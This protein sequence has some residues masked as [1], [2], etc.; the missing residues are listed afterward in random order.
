MATASGTFEMT[1]TAEPPLLEDDGIVLGRM[2]FEKVF[3]GGLIGTS[4]VHMTYARTP[5][6]TSAGYVAIERIAGTLGGCEGSFMVLHTGVS[7]NRGQSLEISIV[8]DSGTGDLRGISGSMN[9]TIVDGGHEY[10]VDYELA[11]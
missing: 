8:P 1:S 3:R 9:I 7:S 4:T 6:E 5:V 2:T 10:T 11:S